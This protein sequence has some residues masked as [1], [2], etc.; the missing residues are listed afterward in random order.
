MVVLLTPQWP[1]RQG[2]YSAVFA[3]SSAT[4]L[5]FFLMV[6]SVSTITFCFMLSVFFS[7]ADTATSVAFLVWFISYLPYTFIHLN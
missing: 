7:K 4:A 6:Y 3:S 5:W 2:E 1:N